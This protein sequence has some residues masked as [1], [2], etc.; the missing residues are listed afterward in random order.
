[1]SIDQRI[2]A[3]FRAIDSIQLR[4]EVFS[5]QLKNAGI[6]LPTRPAASVEYPQPVDS[7]ADD[8]VIFISFKPGD[9]DIIYLETS[10]RA[11]RPSAPRIDDDWPVVY[12]ETEFD[13]RSPVKPK[14]KRRRIRTID[15]DDDHIQHE[16]VKQWA[17]SFI[18]I[19]AK[20]SKPRKKRAAK[21]EELPDLDF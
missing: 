14:Q 3:R 13:E 2:I 17:E 4:R 9:D 8:D 6:K 5:E 10:Q 12:L 20:E 21:V 1:M 18:L 16:Q 19:E 15:D 11:K 7:A